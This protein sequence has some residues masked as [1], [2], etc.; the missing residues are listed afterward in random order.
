M[1]ENEGERDREDLSEEASPYR[2]EENRKKGRVAQSKEIS[3]LFALM[4]T[5]A[6]MYYLFPYLFVEVGNFTKDV[7]TLD[8]SQR[9]EFGTFTILKL[10]LLKAVKLALFLSMPILLISFVV[11][12]TG[13]YIQIGSIFSFEPLKPDLN[14]INPLKG[15]Q[16]YMSMRMLYDGIRIIFKGV[17]VAL[18]AYWLVNSKITEAPSYLLSDPSRLLDGFRNSGL[19]IFWGLCVILLFFAGFDFWLQR[20]EYGKSVRLTKKEA[21][22]EHKEHEGD[23]LVRA[24]IRNIQREMARRRM[25]EAVKEADVV[26]TNPTHIAVALKYD[27]ESMAAPKVIAK[28][29]DFLAQ[30]IKKAAA[31]SNIPMVENVPLA[32]AL[33]KTV[34]IGQA[35]PKTLYQAVAEV[36]AYIYKMKGRRKF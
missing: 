28:G 30:K 9:L 21:K 26:V 3:G 35:I 32:R 23:P 1:A 25:L 6:A 20:W 15:A 19:G 34:K 31:D 36:L 27:K 2:L 10:M 24:R 18:V 11:G 17:T 33:Y 12:V 4:A 22:E 7:Y 29:A 16:K 5:G 8:Y 13:S 14:R